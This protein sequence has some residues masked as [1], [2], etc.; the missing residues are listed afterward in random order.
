MVDTL[1]MNAPDA[2]TNA[3]FSPPGA[4][5]QRN[6]LVRDQ[7]PRERFGLQ[8]GEAYRIAYIAGGAQVRRVGRSVALYL[9]MTE[10]R[11]WDGE[12]AVCLDFVLPQGRPLS[13]LSSQ[14]VDVRSAA[15]NERGQWVLQAQ[16]ALWRRRRAPRRMVAR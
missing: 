11:R 16:D 13:M 6:R 2:A 3:E 1:G 12:S 5:P 4:T 9:G 8:E 7:G 14:I 15:L 10:R